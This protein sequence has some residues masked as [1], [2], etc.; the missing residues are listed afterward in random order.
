MQSSTLI[1]GSGSPAR[2]L[3]ETLL[4]RGLPVSVACP[5]DAVDQFSDLAG[6]SCRVLP[7]MR[8]T[9][10]AGGEGEFDLAAEM[11]GQPAAFSAGRIV[12]AEAARRQPNLDHYGLTATETVWALDRLTTTL[13]NGSLP[14]PLAAGRSVVFLHG[15][16]RESNPAVTREVLNAALALGRDHDQRVFV[17]TGN[18]KVAGEGLEALYRRCRDNGVGVVKFTDRPPE[19]QQK[20]DRV[21]IEFD[22]EITGQRCGLTPALTVVDE[23]FR[24]SSRLSRTIRLLELETDGDGFAQAA[25]V[26]RLPVATN[27]RGVY[28]IGPSRGVQEPETDALDLAGA[29]QALTIESA[30]PAMAASVVGS[31]A[32]CLTCL[33]SCPHKAIVF[34]NRP[35]IVPGACQGCGICAAN[36][37]AEAIAFQTADDRSVG[38]ALAGAVEDPFPES[39]PRLVAFCCARSASVAARTAAMACTPL[40]AHLRIVEVPCGGSVSQDHLL[41]ALENGADGVM[42]LT[43][44]SGN[45][46]AGPGPEQSRARCR[47]LAPVLGAVEDGAARIRHATLAANMGAS[48]AGIVRDFVADLSAVKDIE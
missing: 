31:C 41:T 21:R 10:V 3:A 25:N 28:V 37:P 40:S 48:F 24:P 44:H 33:R 23:R 39:E 29:V 36:C 2:Q 22:D 34:A 12:V 43:C 42:L 15:I 1:I 46:F 13:A 9:G 4:Q 8:L 38:D 26:H 17:L 6:P 7:G 35:K 14:A 5:A 11:D 32:R 45:C 18:L 30:A 19:I 47:Q 20:E 27:R 16:H